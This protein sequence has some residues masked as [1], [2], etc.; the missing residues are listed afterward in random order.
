MNREISEKR[1]VE[2]DFTSLYRLIYRFCDFD[3]STFIAFSSNALNI[4]VGG[5]KIVTEDVVDNR[6]YFF[7]NLNCSTSD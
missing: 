2:F 7:K 5:L 3:V 6:L 4:R 1:R